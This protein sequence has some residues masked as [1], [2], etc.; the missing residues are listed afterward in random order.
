M[1]TFVELLA[2]N[3]DIEFVG[4]FNYRNP[5]T[6]EETAFYVSFGGTVP[7]TSS[8]DD[9]PSQTFPARLSDPGTLDYQLNE[10]VDKI[11]AFAGLVQLSL[12]TVTLDNT[13]AGVG[14]AGPYSGLTALSF[15]KR[16]YV[17]WAGEQGAAFSTFNVVARAKILG[18]P[19]VETGKVIFTMQSPMEILNIPLRA[20]TFLGI[21]TGIR[22]LTSS[23]FATVPHIVEYDL[24][25]YTTV[26]RFR[27]PTISTGNHQ[28]LTSKG[29]GLTDLNWNV[30]IAGTGGIVGGPS[31]ISAGEVFW[32]VSF[33]GVLTLVGR[34]VALYD[35]DEVHTL[36]V[37]LLDKSH[38]YMMIDNEVVAEFNPTVSVDVQ[39]ADILFGAATFS[40]QGLVFGSVLYAGY[41]SP[42][43]ARAATATRINGDETGVVGW[44]PFDDGSGSVLTD[45]SVNANHAALSGVENT[46]W[47]WA[48][49]DLGMPE[50]AGVE[51]PIPLGFAFN[52]PMP[53]HDTIRERGTWNDAV[54]SLG[55]SVALGDVKA[56]GVVLSPTDEGNGVVQFTAGEPA[57]PVTFDTEGGTNQSMYVG[58]LLERLLAFRSPAPF[59]LDRFQWVNGLLPFS[60]G[61]SPSAPHMTLA[62]ATAEILHGSG[63]FLEQLPATGDLAVGALLPPVAPGPY[64]NE[65]VL[66]MLDDSG[67]HFPGVSVPGGASR[68]IGGWIKLQHFA[69]DANSTHGFIGNVGTTRIRFNTLGRLEFLDTALTPTTL[70]TDPLGLDYSGLYFVMGVYDHSAHTRKIY[71]GK[72][73]GVLR[74]IAS[75]SGITG[76]PGGGST[77][78]TVGLGL[79]S[80]VI[81]H[82]QAWQKALS[83]VE[84]KVLF[85]TPPIGTESDLFFYAPMNDGSGTTVL[86][87]A[88]AGSV[89][90][91]FS[92]ALHRWAP[93]LRLDLDGLV[94][95]GTHLQFLRTLSPA[96]KI[97]IGYRRN[98]SPMNASDIAEAVSRADAFELRRPYREVSV[99]NSNTRDDY[100][101]S[102]ALPVLVSPF[103]DAAGGSALARN[104]LT[105][106]GPGRRVALL[107]DAPR[108]SI[109][110]N[111]TDEVM[112]TA[113]AFPELANGLSFRVIQRRAEYARLRAQ[114]GLWSAAPESAGVVYLMTEDGVILL[115]EDDTPILT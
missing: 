66:E 114:L 89:S 50:L 113:Q 69:F 88:G 57:E 22:N 46:D 49:T 4:E 2:S 112:L 24:L 86:N 75:D 27:I 52:I 67:I 54:P 17:L 107:N 65:S 55:D 26:H 79:E 74:E 23:G 48:A 47:E 28:N 73:G 80:Y 19:Q 104:L 103:K 44:W 33:A 31:G 36:V 91:D 59:A 111:L 20:Q 70:T 81:A 100:L 6:D 97:T 14:I 10:E 12:G 93:K 68:S 16:D 11:E 99:V 39:T 41:L 29:A 90:D 34:S 92:S 8:S 51:M 38:A 1:P 43:E 105:R 18:E 76:S 37:S 64:N 87:I 106:F 98:Y 32:R 62:A 115:T 42:D 56:R 77:S 63:L 101:D 94:A 110:L 82:A 35:D 72:K 96:W 21:P 30:G 78:I 9:P 109:A 58:T 45:Y 15:G 102:R 3:A 25:S 95:M 61:W 71:L 7:P 40:P 85:E 5:S 108:E 60:S 53:V 84:V 83:L 13:P